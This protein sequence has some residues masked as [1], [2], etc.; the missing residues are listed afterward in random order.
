MPRK[1][2]ACGQ[3]LKAHENQAEME[4]PYGMTQEATQVDD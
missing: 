4:M 2:G 3:G 1:E